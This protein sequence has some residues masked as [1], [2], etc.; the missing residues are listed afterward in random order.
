[1][2]RAVSTICVVVVVVALVVALQFEKTCCSILVANLVK[3]KNIDVASAEL[4]L[5]HGLLQSASHKQ[6]PQQAGPSRVW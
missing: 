3:R 5:L 6:A 1:M 2:T 4:G